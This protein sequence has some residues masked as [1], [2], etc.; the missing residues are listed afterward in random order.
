MRTGTLAPRVRL[1]SRMPFKSAWMGFGRAALG[2]AA[3]ALVTL[4]HAAGPGF[5]DGLSPDERAACGIAKLSASQAVALDSLVSRDVTLARQGGVTAF[6]SA[7]SARHS[8]QECKASGMDS[9]SS[10]EVAALDVYV[11]RAIALGPPP[12]QSFSYSPSP[13]PAPVPAETV[14]SDVSRTQVHGDV[15]LTVGGGSHGR[16]FYGTS[17]DLFVTDPTGRFTVGVGFDD[18]RGRGLLSLCGPNGPYGPVYGGPPYL[19]DFR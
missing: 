15:S 4:A 7:F 9:L 17:A 5:G 1:T 12:A 2:C 14:V 10:K 3:L 16:S 19:W 13:K 18:Y 6:A 11:A 8:P